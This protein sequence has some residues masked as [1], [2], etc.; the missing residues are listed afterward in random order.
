VV[1]QLATHAVLS[2]IHIFSYYV[3]VCTIFVALTVDKSGL[4]HANEMKFKT[5]TGLCIVRNLLERITYI[6]THAHALNTCHRSELLFYCSQ[7]SDPKELIKCPQRVR[8]FILSN[9]T[10][11]QSQ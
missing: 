9:F 6:H 8:S 4:L 5:N 3:I 7:C 11:C 1:A 10:E 2:S